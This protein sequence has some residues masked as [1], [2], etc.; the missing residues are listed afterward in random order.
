MPAPAGVSGVRLVRVCGPDAVN[1][2]Y[3]DPWTSTIFPAAEPSVTEA[4]S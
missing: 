2:T 4:S 3:G 1:A